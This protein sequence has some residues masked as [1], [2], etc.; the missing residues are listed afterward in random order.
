MIYNGKEFLTRE[1][2]VINREGEELTLTIAGESLQAAFSPEGDFS[3]TD[4]EGMKL[5]EGIYFYIPDETLVDSQEN[6]LFHC[7]AYVDL[8]DVYEVDFDRE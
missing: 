2:P 7:S 6:F 3:D 1:L 8:G 5:D 4:D